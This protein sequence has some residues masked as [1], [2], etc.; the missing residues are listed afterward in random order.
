MSTPRKKLSPGEFMRQVLEDD[1]DR[2]EAEAFEAMTDEEVERDIDAHGDDR[3][4][5]QRAFEREMEM[6]NAA[7]KLDAAATKVDTK[8]PKSDTEVPTNGTSAPKNY[9][10]APSAP[11]VGAAVVPFQRRRALRWSL[12]VAAVIAAAL[13]A[14]PA[15]EMFASNVDPIAPTRD[16]APHGVEF[17]RG[18]QDI[19]RPPRPMSA[20]AAG[21]DDRPAPYQKRNR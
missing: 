6:I 2:G 17:P 5:M 16:K 7:A 11:Q 8:A 20:P 19:D 13:A 3:E 15:I 4:L 12:L 18:H 10:K 21:Q 1:P 9:A 14:L